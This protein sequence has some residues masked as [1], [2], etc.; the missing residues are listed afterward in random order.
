MQE[1]V[2]P[3]QRLLPCKLFGRQWSVAGWEVERGVGHESW[4]VIARPGIARPMVT[5][6]TAEAVEDL[7]PPA[8]R[9]L[10]P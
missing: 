2:L 5:P 7:L 10:T 8:V 6:H 1:F 3:C 4:I 9:G